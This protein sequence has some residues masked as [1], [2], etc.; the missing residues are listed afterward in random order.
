[1]CPNHYHKKAFRWT[2]VLEEK[3]K[4][5]LRAPLIYLRILIAAL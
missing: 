2:E 5:G 4:P 3:N 1:M